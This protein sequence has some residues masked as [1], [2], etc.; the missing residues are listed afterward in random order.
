MN[1]E[2][3][4]RKDVFTQSRYTKN[5]FVCMEIHLSAYL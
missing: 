4:A 2:M 5:N 1:I 3:C